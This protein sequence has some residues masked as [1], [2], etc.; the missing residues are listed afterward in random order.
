M[1]GIILTAGKGSRLYPL[2]KIVPKPLL[3]LYDKPMINY[4]IETL[5]NLGVDDILIIV[6]QDGLEPISKYLLEYFPKLKISYTVQQFQDGIAG[7]LRLAEEF[8]SKNENF[9]L[10][11]GDN[12]FIGDVKKPNDTPTIYSIKVKDPERFG[13]WDEI[14]KKV[15]EKPKEFI[16]NEAVVGLYYLPPESIDYAY[17]IKPSSRGELEITDVLNL[18]PNLNKVSFDG[19]WFDTGTFDSLLEC[20]TVIKESK[21]S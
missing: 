5:V 3:P 21:K 17:K 8:I 19:K 11:L 6:S 20:A 2:T 9:Y 18:I 1:K 12:I 15:V 14:N 4:P 13:V 16:S 10:I 7:A